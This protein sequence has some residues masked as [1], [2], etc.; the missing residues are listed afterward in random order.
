MKKIIALALASTIALGAAAPALAG[1]FGNGDADS[2]AFAADLI[3]DTMQ[4]KGI[5]VVS[6]E[7]AGPN[8]LAFLRTED[9]G[10]KMAILDPV[11]FQPAS[12]RAAAMK[13]RAE[14][15]RL[16]GCVPPPAGLRFRSGASWCRRDRGQTCPAPS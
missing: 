1:P 14:R 7:E 13:V 15:T 2:R 5:D 16:A 12:T 8:I 10:Q 4:R 9:G 11:T 6:I 3:L